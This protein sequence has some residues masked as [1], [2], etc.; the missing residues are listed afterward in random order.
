MLILATCNSVWSLFASSLWPCSSV[1]DRS[2]YRKCQIAAASTAEDQVSQYQSGNH[3]RVVQD[4]SLW[5]QSHLPNSHLST[6]LVSIRTNKQ[7]L[8]RTHCWSDDALPCNWWCRI[9]WKIT[10]PLM[11]QKVLESA[12][13]L[14]STARQESYMACLATLDQK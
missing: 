2:K 6:G 1:I 13:D 8:Y 7:M 4:F 9:V 14:A 5:I 3:R 11:H 10:F 12:L